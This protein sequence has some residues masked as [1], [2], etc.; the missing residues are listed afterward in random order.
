[1]EQ[2]ILIVSCGAKVGYQLEDLSFSNNVN[3]VAAIDKWKEYSDFKDATFT[4]T[5]ELYNNNGQII[6]MEFEYKS[7]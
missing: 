7:Q 6:K 5:N 1:M 2:K 3:A 4:S